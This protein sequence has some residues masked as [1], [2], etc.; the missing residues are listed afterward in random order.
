MYTEL[1]CVLNSRMRP[2]CFTTPGVWSGNFSPQTI[3]F[4]TG[5]AAAVPHQLLI[6]PVKMGVVYTSRF[7]RHRIWHQTYVVVHASPT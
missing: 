6:V 4:P 1:K 7:R 5:P 2:D 3:H